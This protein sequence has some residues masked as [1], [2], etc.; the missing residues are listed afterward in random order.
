LALL[1]AFR[2]FCQA[3]NC[4]GIDTTNHCGPL[5]N[6]D[7]VHFVWEHFLRFSYKKLALALSPRGAAK[8][9]KLLC[10]KYYRAE[11]DAWK[12]IVT[13]DDCVECHKAVMEPFHACDLS[14]EC[15]C[16]IYTRQLPTLADSARYVLFN[17]TIYIDSFKL[18]VEKTYSQHVYAVCSN[19]VPLDNLLP[20]ENPTIRLWYLHD[21][22]S[23]YK[24][25]HDCPG[26]GSWDSNTVKT[27]TSDD[28]MIDDLISHKEHFWCH[29]CKMGSSCQ[30]LVLYMGKTLLYRGKTRKRKSWK[31]TW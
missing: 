17:Y 9:P 15:T 6:I 10:L 18:A 8:L 14:P 3:C 27:Y 4:F 16:K 19:R 20:P 30:I 13:C 21:I 28:A 22:N 31:K 1:G 25:H 24:H 23:P 7:L 12:D 2:R 11:S 5:S 26:D 29:H